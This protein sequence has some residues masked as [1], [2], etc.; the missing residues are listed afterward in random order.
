MIVEKIKRGLGHMCSEVLWI[1]MAKPWKLRI[2]RIHSSHFL[3]CCTSENV[4]RTQIGDYPGSIHS[5]CNISKLQFFWSACNS[6]NSMAKSSH[7]LQKCNRNSGC[8][9][10]IF[11]P[12]FEQIIKKKGKG[13]ALRLPTKHD[14]AAFQPL[15]LLL[16]FQRWSLSNR[17]NGVNVVVDHP[18]CYLIS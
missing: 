6:P 3:V 12:C 15:A 5:F 1:I 9:C 13:E 14:W 10:I 11:W 18:W 17:C 16:P 8:S 4:L 7:F 2:K